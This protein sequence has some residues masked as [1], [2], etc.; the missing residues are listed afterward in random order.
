MI[1]IRRK[2]VFNTE[3]YESAEIEVTVT[4]IPDDEDPDNISKQLD[5]AMA[6]ELDRIRLAT[7][8]EVDDTTLYTWI[9]VVNE[10]VVDAQH[11]R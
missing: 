10:E 2:L 8:R 3:R 5:D 1:T 11:R 9:D 7:S 4:G 6:P